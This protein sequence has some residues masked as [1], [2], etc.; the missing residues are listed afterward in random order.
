VADLYSYKKQTGFTLQQ[1]KA[2]KTLE[3][4]G[5]NVNQFIRAAVKE[6]IQRDWKAIKDE[7]EKIKMPF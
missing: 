2:F 5:V 4:Y 6:K 1:Q 7:K 3:A